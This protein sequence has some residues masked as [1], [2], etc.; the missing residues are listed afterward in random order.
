MSELNM[1]TEFYFDG[2]KKSMLN[3][4]D[5]NELESV[6]KDIINKMMKQKS[7]LLHRDYHSRNIMIKDNSLFVIDYQD[8]RLGPYT[9][10]L[11]SLIIDPY[12]YLSDNLKKHIIDR[13]TSV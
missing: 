9:Y 3:S 6:Y 8:A 7:L 10:D 12:I 2:Y 13:Y 1:T 5:K 11:A 4:T